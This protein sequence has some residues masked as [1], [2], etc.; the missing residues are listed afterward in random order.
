MMAV[1]GST[2]SSSYS[3]Y[4]PYTSSRST[5]AAKAPDTDLK[6]RAKP[7]LSPESPDAACMEDT[8]L[9]LHSFLGQV[10]NAQPGETVEVDTDADTFSWLTKN[11]DTV[12]EMYRGKW[13]LIDKK[14][15]V[16]IPTIIHESLMN[17]V[18]RALGRRKD[19]TELSVASNDV[20]VYNGIKTPDI[21]LY[22]ERY[23]RGDALGI[24]SMSMEVGYTETRTKLIWDILRLVLGLQGSL[25]LAL[26]VNVHSA[27]ELIYLEIIA[28]LVQDSGTLEAAEANRF[29]HGKVYGRREYDDEWEIVPQSDPA[30]FK[31]FRMLPSNDQSDLTFIECKLAKPW[32]IT[33][34]D[35][36]NIYIPAKSLFRET[37]DTDEPLIISGADL[38]KCCKKRYVY[39]EALKAVKTD[40]KAEGLLR[41][42]KWGKVHY[43]AEEEDMKQGKRR[44]IVG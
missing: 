39:N 27:K 42:R 24:P 43:E 20:P 31:Y 32:K 12:T 44:R 19:S 16:T 30:S 28:C 11:F 6:V 15:I 13:E 1:I 38:W 5:A 34:K 14:V 17:E 8:P 4:T 41:K 36:D 10:Q 35:Q 18:T 23:S 22:D 37:R 2:S 7:N 26:G 9:P 3:L 29:Q 40:M 25:L 33:E 21:N